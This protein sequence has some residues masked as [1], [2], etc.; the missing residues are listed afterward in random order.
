MIKHTGIFASED[1][2]KD[3]RARS[4]EVRDTPVVRVMGR[5][6][7]EDVAE[8]FNRRVDELAVK[9]G[10]PTPGLCGGEVNHYG[11]DAD[12]QFTV[13]EPDPT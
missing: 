9:Y 2:I 3:L 13:Y 1:D 6:L 10:L 8:N 11:V 5:W 4:K 12:G 7:H